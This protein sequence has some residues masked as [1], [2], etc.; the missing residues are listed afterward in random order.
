MQHFLIALQFLTRIP[1]SL[2][3]PPSKAEFGNSILYYPLVGLLIGLI[4]SG[5]NSLLS[6]A[7]DNIRAAVV[8]TSWVL[9]TG[10]LHLDGLADSVDAWIG[11]HGDRERTLVIMKDPVCGP[12][13]VISLILLLLLKFA[14]LASLEHQDFLVILLI[15]AITRG[16]ILVTLLGLPYLREDGLG[17]GF[18]TDLPVRPAKKLLAVMTLILLLLA[19]TAGIWFVL[20]SVFLVIAAVVIQK[21][22]LGGYTGDT[23]G[24]QVEIIEMLL[25]LGAIYSS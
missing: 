24:A 6:G 8:L 12:M 16:S 3:H 18:A 14:A 7:T 17:K 5:M 10:A 20:L 25:L 22:W 21:K 13:G 2:P 23:L 19:F 1:V 9:I 4:L 11:G 15:P